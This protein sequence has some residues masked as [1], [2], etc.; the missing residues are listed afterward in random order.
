MK[1]SEIEKI[2]DPIIVE[3]GID[4][5]DED[6]I[7]S[8][9]EVEPLVYRAE[10]EGSDLYDVE[11]G[12]DSQGKVLYTECNCPYDKGPVCK[13]TVAVLLEI[14]EE[15]FRRDDMGVSSIPKPIPG[16]NLSARLS[17]LGKEE[18]IELL[19]QLSKEVKE[20]ELALAL[21]FAVYDN[22]ADL[23]RFRKVIRSYIKKNSDRHGFVAYRNVA[24]AVTGADMVI[25]KA[26]EL[27]EQGHHLRSM[28]VS[29]C[30]LREMAGLFQ[31][32]DDSDVIVGGIIQDSLELVQAAASQPEAMPVHDRAWL[33]SQ[34]LQEMRHP[35]LNG[36]NEVQLSLLESA[37]FLIDSPEER[38]EW[39]R[40][41]LDLERRE[42]SQSYSGPYF[43]ENIS[44][45]RYRVIQ[46]MDGAEQATKFIEDHLDLTAFRQMAIDAAM[47]RSQ[48][49]QALQ[50]AVQGERQDASRG[51]PGLVK[52]WKR[53][54]YEIY[55]HTQQVEQQIKLA[56][57]FVLDGDYTYY[58]EY[59]QFIRKDEWPEAY[60]RLIHTLGR[61][62]R[63]WSAD[64]L[65]VRV[66]I[67]E[68]DTRRL[69]DYVRTNKWSVAIH[70]PHLVEEY[71][72]EVFDIFKAV[73]L[74]EA[75]HSTNRKA[76]RKVCGV[77]GQLVEAGGRARAEEVIKHLCFHY[78]NKPAFMDELQQI[79]L[80]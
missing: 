34:L 57:E 67:E 63:N 16:T 11:V 71:A 58:L 53:C 43:M 29:F 26:R 41:L 4:Y 38:R 19:V 27:W 80:N 13:H 31:A 59:K 21:K 7:L 35:E 3:R 60:E 25:E 74:A 18:L 12:L 66:L 68:K 36:W 37:S 69:M 79:K 14:R 61:S 28:E 73:I 75:S 5:W 15:R 50:L 33:F 65:Y 48:Y 40:K 78:S 23:D 54:R 64:A 70:Y 76:Y 62:T 9:E 1:L 52:G 8:I 17:K 22:A 6:C 42:T 47:E 44:K 72:E 45:L 10:V 55:R 51:Y 24:D 77:I 30:I 56:E 32:C 20:V 2:I 46:R 49:E 39:E